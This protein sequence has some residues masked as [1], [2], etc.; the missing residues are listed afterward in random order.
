MQEREA[1]ELLV[2]SASRRRRVA[3][4]AGR[5]EEEV[6]DLLRAFAAMKA[7]A[8]NMSALMKLG[9]GKGE[10]AAVTRVP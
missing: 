6:S 8:K 10:C 3:E 1:P 2:K 9:Q 4:G 7:Q 5:T